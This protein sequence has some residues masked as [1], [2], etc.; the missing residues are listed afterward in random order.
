MAVLFS[1]DIAMSSVLIIVIISLPCSK[2]T[3]TFDPSV[4]WPWLMQLVGPFPFWLVKWM[5]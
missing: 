2:N 3:P 4:P 1:E 5:P